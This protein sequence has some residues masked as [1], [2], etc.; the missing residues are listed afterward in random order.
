MTAPSAGDP[1]ALLRGLVD[2]RRS[3]VLALR[4]GKVAA[5]L[6]LQDGRLVF[7]VS[8]LKRLQA[9]DWLEAA[10]LSTAAAVADA[11]R[12]TTG[13]K[14]LVDNLVR[15]HGGR[16]PELVEAMRGLTREIALDALCWSRAESAFSAGMPVLRDQILLDEPAGALL[17]AA[18]KRLAA[19]PGAGDEPE[20]AGPAGPD[21]WADVPEVQEFRNRVAHARTLDHFALLE[22]ERAAQPEVIR[23]RYYELARIYHP[24]AIQGVLAEACQDLAEEHFALITEAYNVLTRPDQRKEYLEQL[25]ESAGRGEPQRQDP[26][27]LARQNFQQAQKSAAAGELHDAV[28]FFQNAARMD[29]KRAEYHRELGIVQ[30]QNPRWQKA[31][32]ESLQRAVSLER[33]DARAWVHLGQLYQRNGLK[34]RAV[35][36]YRQTLQWDPDNFEAMSG[37]AELEDEGGKGGLKGLFGRR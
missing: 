24:D 8:N 29:P 14:Q 30:M 21:P 26:N 34:T 23:K 25:R 35:E 1:L 37:L 13:S 9:G 22:V 4:R 7:A 36:A 19:A 20:P 6:C 3:G 5:H 27:Q 10:G 15:R 16:R 11:G 32:E 33:T 18:E 28:Q 17:A 12:E 2:D 31:A